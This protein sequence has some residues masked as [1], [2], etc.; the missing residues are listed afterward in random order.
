MPETF[1]PTPSPSSAAGPRIDHPGGSRTV[2]GRQPALPWSARLAPGETT[3]TTTLP[4]GDFVD[5]IAVQRCIAGTLE[6]GAGMNRAERERAVVEL[7]RRGYSNPE[8]VHRTGVS[9]R[10]IG[11]ILQRR[12]SAT[13]ADV[14]YGPVVPTGCTS[15]QAARLRSLIATRATDPAEARELL[16]ALGLIASLPASTRPASARVDEDGSPQSEREWDGDR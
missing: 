15:Q 1:T 3:T 2:S 9:I 14:R 13:A 8:I 7:Y 5:D 4:G 10:T 12:Q 16:L 11:S 6:R